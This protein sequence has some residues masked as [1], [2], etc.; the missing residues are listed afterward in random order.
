[1]F[2]YILLDKGNTSTITGRV[3]DLDVSHTEF[4]GTNRLISLS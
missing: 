3:L 1:M 4:D 2:F